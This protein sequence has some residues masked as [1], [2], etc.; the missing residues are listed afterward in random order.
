M[1]DQRLINGYWLSMTEYIIDFCL[2]AFAGAC[3]QGPVHN[4]P[5]ILTGQPGKR[6]PLGPPEKRQGGPG[7]AQDGPQGPKSCAAQ[8]VTRAR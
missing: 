4:T 7:I 3:L 1:V 6:C 8:R 2:L 5:P